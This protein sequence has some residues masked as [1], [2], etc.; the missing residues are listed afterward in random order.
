LCNFILDVFFI[1]GGDGRK[2]RGNSGKLDETRIN[3]DLK[4]IMSRKKEREK[5]KQFWIN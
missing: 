2:K 4:K 1:L 3:L 5:E